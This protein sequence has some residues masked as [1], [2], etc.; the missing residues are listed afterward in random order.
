MEEILNILGRSNV[1]TLFEAAKNDEVRYKLELQRINAHMNK[2]TLQKIQADSIFELNDKRKLVYD[3]G[4][5]YDVWFSG[6]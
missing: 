2:N 3:M 4:I 5:T 6:K 1:K